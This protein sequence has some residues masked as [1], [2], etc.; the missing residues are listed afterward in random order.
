[1][2]SNKNCSGSGAT[3]LQAVALETCTA[4]VGMNQSYFGSYE[5]APAVSGFV[6]D[7][8]Y[9]TSSCSGSPYAVKAYYAGDCLQYN[10]GY[11]IFLIDSLTTCSQYSVQKYSDSLC[12]LPVGLATNHSISTLGLTNSTTCSRNTNFYGYGY[13]KMS[14]SSTNPVGLVS[15]PKIT[16]K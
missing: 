13:G 7:A 11:A 3:A 5:S 1:M 16:Q 10:N 6:F 12:K 8:Y 2:F 14:C 15:Y 9:S 4:V